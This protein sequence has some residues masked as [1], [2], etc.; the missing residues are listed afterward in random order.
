MPALSALHHILRNRNSWLQKSSELLARLFNLNCSRFIIGL[1]LIDL[2]CYDVTHFV[3]V[4]ILATDL[5]FLWAFAR[6][7][8]KNSCYCGAGC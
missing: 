5:E 3:C 7:K 1:S 2:L 6:P 4:T 8:G